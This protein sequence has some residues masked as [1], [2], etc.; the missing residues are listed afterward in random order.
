MSASNPVRTAVHFLRNSGFLSAEQSANAD[1]IGQL[2]TFGL[3]FKSNLLRLLHQLDRH[4]LFPVFPVNRLGHLDDSLRSQLLSNSTL[5]SEQ[6]ASSTA[7]LQP[8]A[9]RTD[10]ISKDQHSPITSIGDLYWKC[11]HEQSLAIYCSQPHALN[12]FHWMQSN[13]HRLWRSVGL[14]YFENEFNYANVLKS[15]SFIF[16]VVS[17]SGQL[18]FERDAQRIRLDSTVE[19]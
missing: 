16:I 19:H 3:L 14:A 17:I 15:E 6:S 5:T 12:T 13:R 4:S 18:S 7:H 8:F 1:K 9:L 2:S 10:S 11:E